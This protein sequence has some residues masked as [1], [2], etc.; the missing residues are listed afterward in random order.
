[1]WH[2]SVSVTELGNILPDIVRMISIPTEFNIEGRIG[3]DW[4]DNTYLAVL[5][6]DERGKYMIFS[7]DKST[8][9]LPQFKEINL[10]DLM[11]EHP[12]LFTYQMFVTTAYNSHMSGEDIFNTLEKLF[13]YMDKLRKL[14][15]Q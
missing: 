7:V 9:N 14:S 3:S 10:S 4:D 13:E 11:K 6:P 2:L 5:G 1:M 15:K 12:Q 8:R